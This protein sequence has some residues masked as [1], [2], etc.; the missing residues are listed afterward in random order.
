MNLHVTSVRRNILK[1]IR[2]RTTAIRPKIT[3]LHLSIVLPGICKRS[4][5]VRCASQCKT[6]EAIKPKILR[7]YLKIHVINRVYLS[8]KIVRLKTIAMTENTS[9]LETLTHIT[10]I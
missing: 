5:L 1:I 3:K 6:P 4:H 10:R 9:S 7:K 2:I 8:D